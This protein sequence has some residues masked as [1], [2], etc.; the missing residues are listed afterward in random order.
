MKGCVKHMGIMY[1][2]ER[3]TGEG[4]AFGEDC[5]KNDRSVQVCL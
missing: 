3:K 4:W 1:S 2:K 5:R